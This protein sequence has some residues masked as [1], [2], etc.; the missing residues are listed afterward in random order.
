MEIRKKY[1]D[2]ILIYL[3]I[4]YLVK[5]FGYAPMRTTTTTLS[6]NASKVDVDDFG[7]LKIPNISKKTYEYTL[8]FLILLASCYVIRI[9]TVSTT[10]KGG[11]IKFN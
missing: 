1:N 2:C 4:V 11:G 5:L 7:V 8:F 10:M 9:V 6:S 3:H